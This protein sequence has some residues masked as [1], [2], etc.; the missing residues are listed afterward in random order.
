LL[1][2]FFA[3][4]DYAEIR[5][6]R[7]EG[8]IGYLRL[9]GRDTRDECGLSGVWIAD[10][11]YI[12][13]EFE[14]KAVN[15]FLT[16]PSHFVLAR[17]LMGAGGKVLVATTPTPAFGDDD[18]FVGFREVVNEFAGLEVVER[19]ADRD[20]QDGRFAVQACAV[21]AH[22]VLPALGLV[23]GVVAEVNQCVVPL[24][25]FHDDIAP[26]AAISAR[27]SAARDELLAAKGHAAVTAV[28][29][30]HTDFCLVDE[31]NQLTFN[32]L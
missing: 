27:G 21:G 23:L 25:G 20:L 12:C 3:D 15:A 32:A 29:S 5:L 28:A 4:R 24:G 7:G 6:K 9:G 10:E 16:G 13:E 18:A 17:S 31:H 11:A 30:L 14:L 19:G 2:R 26:A 22:A 8:I 1:V